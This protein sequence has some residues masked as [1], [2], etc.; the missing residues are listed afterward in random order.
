MRKKGILIIA[1][2]MFLLVSMTSQ[3]QL[4]AYSQNFEGL[5]QADP[6][7]L[8]NNGWLY[9]ANVWDSGWNYLYPYGPGPAPNGT[10]GFCSIATGQGGA[11]QGL[12]QLVVYSDYN[13][14]DH[15]LGFHIEANVFQEQVVGPGD[16]GTNWIFRFDAKK[17]DIAGASTALAFIKTL[18]PGAGYALTNFLTIDTT[19]LPVTWGT[20]SMTIAIDPTL[21]GQILQ[22]GFLTNATNYEASGNFYDN[23]VFREDV[24]LLVTME[25]M[26]ATATGD[27][28]LVQW[29]TAT[30]L[31]TAGFR[32]LR[33][34]GA[35]HTKSLVPVSP[36]IAPAGTSL[37]GAMYEFLDAGKGA[38]HATRYWIEDVDNM[39]RITRHG[40][41]EVDRSI[42]DRKPGTRRAVTND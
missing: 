21:D 35:M 9:F 40:P 14:T 39:G 7:A 4:S 42:R 18:D 26:S 32:V 11:P 24:P 33:E 10:P 41:I 28:V 2:A 37:T 6:D 29:K 23:I 20:Y 17:G 12:Q 16:V 36:T 34:D 8:G 27:S 1:V 38:R 3:A 25:S 31:D 30:E 15:G 5:A 19:N 22:F 13:N